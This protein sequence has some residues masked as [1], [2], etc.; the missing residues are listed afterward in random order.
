[1]NVQGGGGREGRAMVGDRMGDA[2]PVGSVW[3]GKRSLPQMLQ[4]A[5]AVTMPANPGGE[6]GGLDGILRWLGGGT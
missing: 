1:M 2:P 5:T 4:A 6:D 3:V